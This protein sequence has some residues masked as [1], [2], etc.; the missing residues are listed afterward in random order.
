MPLPEGFSPWEHLQAVVLQSY[1]RTVR[2]QFRDLGGDDWDEDITSGRGALR[3]ACTVKDD[4]SANM[5]AIRMMLFYMTL[6]Q[7]SDLHPPL[8]TMPSDR[9]QQTVRFSPQI[10]LYFREDLDEVEQGY[11]PI[12]SQIS[13]RIRGETE[14]TFTP[15]NALT[16]ANRIRSEF[17]TG[18]G[19]RWRKGR[20][21]LSY[22]DLE[23]GYNL[24]IHAVSESEG[25]QVIAKVLSLQGDTIDNDNLVIAELGGTPPIV[26]GT[27]VIYGESRR[28]PRKRPVGNVRFRYAEVHIWGVNKAVTL[29]DMTLRRGNA[30]IYA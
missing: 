23:R 2:S 26:P 30:L 24:A 10:T 8:Y 1:N 5:V 11:K 4:D 3:V 16:W 20:V 28:L 22:R 13:F 27:Q 12:D 6:R 29:V 7:A 25:R 21:K 14:T 17:A 19:W 9:Y 15:A 18:G